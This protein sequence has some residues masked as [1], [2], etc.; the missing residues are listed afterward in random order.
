MEMAIF[1]AALLYDK[2][3]KSFKWLFK[4]FLNA[5]NGRK[6]KSISTN[7][8]FAIAK[9]LTK[10]MPQTCHGFCTWHIM[11]NGMKKL[12]NLIKNGSLFLRDFND[13]MHKYENESEYEEARDSD[14]YN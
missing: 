13:C 12:G 4:S 9:A 1:G 8:D 3:T 10:V 7:Q 14:L 11:Q 5:H 2:T 6:S